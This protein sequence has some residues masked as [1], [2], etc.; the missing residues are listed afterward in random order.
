MPCLDFA[1]V[2]TTGTFIALALRYDYFRLAED[3]D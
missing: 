2:V 3:Q 1:G